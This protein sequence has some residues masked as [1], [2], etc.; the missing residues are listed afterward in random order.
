[1]DAIATAKHHTG[2]GNIFVH[3]V[4]VTWANCD[5]AKI[6]Y[7]GYIP[8]WSLEAINAWWEEHLGGDG[9]YQME[10]DR[11]IGTPFVHMTMDFNLPVTPRHRLMCQVAPS[12]LG[13]RSVEFS[14]VGRQ[15]GKTCF[16]GRFVSVFTIADQFKPQSAPP[17]I[18]QIVDPLI[19]EIFD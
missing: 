12:R 19:K 2:V 14:V 1:M 18:R 3:E 4:R 11:N 9:W 5:P 15:D 13:D 10:L 8:W 6:A 17:D 7:S 16:T